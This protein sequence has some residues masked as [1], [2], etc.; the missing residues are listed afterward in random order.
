MF[1]I[2]EEL[3]RGCDR[4]AVLREGTVFGELSGQDI[5]SENLLHMIAGENIIEAGGEL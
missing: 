2:Y 3:V 5:T 1:C 4:I